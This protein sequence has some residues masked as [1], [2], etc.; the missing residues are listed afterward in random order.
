MPRQARRTPLMA[1]RVA[2]DLES[3]TQPVK[4]YQGNLLAANPLQMARTALRTAFRT[5]P[6]A[7]WRSV[8][9]LLEKT[10]EVGEKGGDG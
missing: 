8:V 9:I 7:R 4:T 10:D 1:F 6:G 5:Y 3:D 2:V